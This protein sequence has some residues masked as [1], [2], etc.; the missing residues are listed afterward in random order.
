MVRI[1]SKYIANL[2]AQATDSC[3]GMT[4]WFLYKARIEKH[5]ILINHLHQSFQSELV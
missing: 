5:D 4:L 2:A 1:V 3:I